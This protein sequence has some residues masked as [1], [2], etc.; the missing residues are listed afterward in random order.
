VFWTLRNASAVFVGVVLALTACNNV[1][2][3]RG[4]TAVHDLESGVPK[5]LRCYI[6]LISSRFD[7]LQTC[8]RC[9]PSRFAAW[10]IRCDDLLEEHRCGLQDTM[11]EHVLLSVDRLYVF[12]TLDLRGVSPRERLQRR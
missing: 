6:F 4:Y 10:W 8:R 3:E 5:P 7:M 1:G 2:P 9:T 12:W 11:S